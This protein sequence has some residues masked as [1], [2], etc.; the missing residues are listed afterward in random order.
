MPGTV[1]L[2]VAAGALVA[3]LDGAAALRAGDPRRLARV[4]LVNL[5]LPLA[6]AGV[7]ALAAD[8]NGGVWLQVLVTLAIVTPLGPILYRLAFQPLAAASP[9]ILLIVAVAVHYVLTGLGLLFFGGEGCARA[10]SRMRR[11]RS[12]CSTSRRRAC[13]S[14]R[15]APD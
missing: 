11:S 1:Y 8:E 15:R 10:P 9:L 13:G 12:A 3:L 6:V 14:W 7:A 2:L 4:L 5:G